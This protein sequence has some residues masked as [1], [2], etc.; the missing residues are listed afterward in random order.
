VNASAV[1]SHAT[2]CGCDAESVGDLLV[3]KTITVLQKQNL[4]IAI[5]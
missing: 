4:A 3:R 1:E 2:G 5:A